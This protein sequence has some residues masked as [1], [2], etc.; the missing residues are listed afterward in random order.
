MAALNEAP[1][2]VNAKS[3]IFIHEFHLKDLSFYLFL[4]NKS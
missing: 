2:A 1:N 3:S 4:S